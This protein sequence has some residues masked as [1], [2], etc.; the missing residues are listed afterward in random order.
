M[1]DMLV[2]QTPRPAVVSLQLKSE[3]GVRS[4]LRLRSDRLRSQHLGTFGGHFLAAACGAGRGG[5]GA[6]RGG[7]AAAIRGGG[8]AGLAICAA[9]RGGGS[10]GPARRGGSARCGCR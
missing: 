6:A 9:G 2:G 5:G 4:D 7:G 1:P 3:N 8:G 10:G